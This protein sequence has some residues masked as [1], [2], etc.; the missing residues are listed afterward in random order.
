MTFESQEEL[1]VNNM[2]I[3]RNIASKYYT[4]K[5]GLEYEDLVSYGVMGLIDA[6]K[7][8]DET[9]GVKFSTY[10][11]IRVSSFIIDEIRK[12]SPVSRTYMGKIKEYNKSI[13]EL[14]NKYFREPSIDEISKHMN[15][16]K[17]EVTIIKNKIKNSTNV[18]MDS[19]VTED[20]KEFTFKDTIEDTTTPCPEEMMEQKELQNILAKALD[21]LKEKDRLVLSLYY[22]EE[23]TLKEIGEILGV[24]ESRVS[25]LNNRAISNLREAMKKLNYMD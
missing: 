2:N 21:T 20:E 22:Y 15:I 1:I 11:S 17:K 10:A 8:F 23:L 9:R 6:S 4:D 25:Q 16:S 7:K 3:V 14:R 24:S 5:I 18:S 13:D 12:Y 19:M